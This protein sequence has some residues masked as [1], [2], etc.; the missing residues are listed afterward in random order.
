MRMGVGKG[1]SRRVNKAVT[2]ASR[3][4]VD[5]NFFTGI[6]YDGHKWD[7]WIKALDAQGVDITS[8]YFG[9]TTTKTTPSLADEEREFILNEVFRDAVDNGAINLPAQIDVKGFSFKIKRDDPVSQYAFLIVEYAPPGAKKKRKGSTGWVN[10]LLDREIA[11]AYT[12]FSDFD[13][14]IRDAA[15]SS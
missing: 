3:A 6:V 5:K 12:L 15:R 2:A 9:D 10:Y 13:K 8:F 1:Q 4:K 11:T 14:A 7:R